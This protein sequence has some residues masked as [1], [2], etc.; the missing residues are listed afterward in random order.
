MISRKPIEKR[1]L[2]FHFPCCSAIHILA[3]TCQQVR[4]ELGCANAK[5]GPEER[6]LV[7][8]FTLAIFFGLSIITFFFFFP[9]PLCD[10]QIV[11]AYSEQALIAIITDGQVCWK[12]RNYV[13]YAHWGNSVLVQVIHITGW[14][15]SA[16]LWLEQGAIDKLQPQ[17]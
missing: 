17:F 10:S 9:W 1:I 6:F 15:M 11:Q 16:C 3:L 2:C 13:L 12:A 5:T 4:K 14:L 8:Y 7:G